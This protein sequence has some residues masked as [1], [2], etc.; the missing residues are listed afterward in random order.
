MRACLRGLG[1]LV[2]ALAVLPLLA[3]QEAV[4]KK[5]AKDE[6]EAQKADKADK[7]DAKDAADT[8]TKTKKKGEDTEKKTEKKEKLV[9]GA[10]FPGKL[11]EMDANSQ[12]NFTVE[13]Q[14][15]VPNPDGQRNLFNAQQNWQRRQFDISRNRNRAQAAQQMQQLQFDIA[16]EM[17]KLQAG[18]VKMEPKDVKLQAAE[19]MRVRTVNLPLDYDEKGNVKKY[20]KKE[21][22][23]LRGPEKN[24]PGYKAEFEALRAGQYVQ[25][26]LAKNEKNPVPKA[27]GAKGGAKDGGAAALPPPGGGGA[28]KAAKLPGDDDV[29]IGEQRPSVVM[30]VIVA[31][32]KER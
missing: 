12:K 26:F 7:A 22:E 14:I 4:K 8:K 18:L 17:P 24:L 16:R 9:Y 19:N 3:A 21:L 31:E 27:K 10:S 20:T 1:V 15:P 11:K 23:E 6:I 30:I 5:T 29:N 28:G 32:P 25:V 2:V 13:V